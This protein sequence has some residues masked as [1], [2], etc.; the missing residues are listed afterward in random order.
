MS[1]IG[2]NDFGAGLS[3]PASQA[4]DDASGGVPS[5]AG[6]FGSGLFGR[7]RDAFAN[8]PQ[9]NTENP[10]QDRVNALAAGR[11][12]LQQSIDN[13]LRAF[14]KPRAWQED[15]QKAGELDNQLAQTQ[16]AMQNTAADRQAAYNGG[17]RP[18]T[19]NTLPVNATAK[20]IL[21]AW[22]GDY[23]GGS[24]NAMKYLG[25]LGDAG[26]GALAENEGNFMPALAER[27][28]QAE[29]VIDKL[30]TAAQA[31][32]PQYAA[33]LA[34]LKAQG[35][36]PSK[37]LADYVPNFTVPDKADA[38]NVRAQGVAG[39][40]AQAK[41][42]VAQYNTKQ[43]SLGLASPVADEKEE[44]AVQGSMFKGSDSAPIGHGSAT[45]VK[46]PNNEYG[47]VFPSGSAVP[48]SYM[49]PTGEGKWS[50]SSPEKVD[51]FNKIIASEQ[52]K[53]ALS[54][55]KLVKKAQEL[56]QNPETF[57]TAAGVTM[58]IGELGAVERDLS[59]GSRAAGTPGMS[60]MFE[61]VGLGSVDR[62]L[63]KARN[64]TSALKDWIDG[65]KK[66]PEPRLSD[67]TIKG[68]KA[69][70]QFK[71]D[72]SR[73]EISERMQ[74]PME[75]AGR[76]GIALNK[77]GLDK[78]LQNDPALLLAA[79]AGRDAFLKDYKSHKF[80]PQ[81]DAA[82]L[83]RQG[84]TNPDAKS[85]S[86]TQDVDSVPPRIVA[87]PGHELPPP[88]GKVFAPQGGDTQSRATA[89][90]HYAK[91]VN[92]GMATQPK[93][94]DPE[95][96][97]QPN[98]TPN[99]A[100]LLR[101]I[102]GSESNGDNPNSYNLIVGGQRLTNYDDHPGNINPKIGVDTKNGHSTASGAYQ[103]TKTTWNEVADKY[104]NVLDRDKNG[105]VVFTPQNQDKAAWLLA[106]ERYN[107]VTGGGNLEKDLSDPAKHDTVMKA[108]SGTWTSLPGG[109]EPN[110]ATASRLGALAG[111][112]KKVAMAFPPTA[113]SMALFNV[114]DARKALKDGA[115][116]SAPVLGSVGGALGGAAVGGIAGGVVGGAAGGAAGQAFKNYATGK[117]L[118]ENVGREAG[119][120][121]AAGL[122]PA[123][124]PI[125]GAIARSVGAGVVGATNEALTNPEAL[126]SDIL[127]KGAETGA[128]A[129]GGETA[130]R[131]VGLALGRTGQLFN[132]FTDETKQQLVDAGSVIAKGK[133]E[134]PKAGAAGV[135]V[136]ETA[137]AAHEA[138]LKAYEGAVQ[139]SK[140]HGLD[141]EDLAH[142]VQQ[143]P[144]G[145]VAV[146]KVVNA[147]QD[148]LGERHQEIKA[149]VGKQQ[150]QAGTPEPAPGTIR[151][152]H[153][154]SAD[155]DPTSYSAH[156]TP[157][158]NYARNFGAGSKT[159]HYVDMT[160]QEAAAQGGID[161]I[162]GNRPR[163]FQANEQTSSRLRPLSTGQ[164]L[165]APKQQPLTDGP[166]SLVGKHADVPKEYEGRAVQA[167]NNI[168]QP[169]KD[170]EQKY[171]QIFQERSKLLTEYRE[172]LPQ[173][174][175]PNA[176]KAAA[177]KAIADNVGDQ[178][179]NMLKYVYG[180]RGKAM[181]DKLDTLHRDYAEFMSASKG[182]D[183]VENMA[184]PGTAGASATAAFNRYAKDDAGARSVAEILVKG[185]RNPR[186][187]AGRNI[188]FMSALLASSLG[189]H[190]PTAALLL[191]TEGPKMLNEWALKRAAGA[192][193]TF[194]ELLISKAR[195][196]VATAK[197]RGAAATGRVAAEAVQ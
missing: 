61:A 164:N 169:A 95:G 124:R 177:L 112:T 81:G 36:N 119:L 46:L 159:V 58:V 86:Q 152:Y 125:L 187:D 176:N 128:A 160:P 79:N 1:D 56:A 188:K 12:R 121:G 102:R 94:G 40:L 87:S 39:Q 31:G 170:W 150:R 6:P 71:Y 25:T 104:G 76:N 64:E 139:T 55:Y 3:D 167:E 8:R 151:Y 67:S 77:T 143:V 118:A 138:D 195:Q 108:L 107:K 163:I 57:R 43:S 129:L 171:Q 13:P 184:K 50:N 134:A 90:L 17:L 10:V 60:K 175:A 149:D 116:D 110:G 179:R 18:E 66:G 182:G 172:A 106:Q 20:T 126:P 78:E 5:S 154:A 120:G 14:L 84:T 29:T 132:K 7:Q 155:A 146:N 32:Q 21:N 191:A 41:N 190:L 22:V 80:V 123:G 49:K 34:Q 38:W 192:P 37:V 2:I 30:N 91:A 144:A 109:S 72:Q 47:S 59:E 96:P 103:F 168:T 82:I 100:N 9:L 85:F 69:A 135:P 186:S 111:Y 178:Q 45:T 35:I 52:N 156:L 140:D 99:G 166:L 180:P 23:A 53:G 93:P 145:K 88:G 122:M 54:D 75:F 130:F 19:L 117:P 11:R 33:T 137:K 197:S 51:Q 113:A 158:Q 97:I 92:G 63:N 153:G 48:D 15:V 193:T 83:L 133:P 27:N 26:K 105:K 148:A 189:L 98:V 142:A 174:D 74:Q 28:T 194:K 62:W 65:G 68:I 173:G 24:W 16:Q 183:V 101:T 42:A 115:V 89:E 147:Q 162:N 44:K 161:E 185:I 4:A 127:T 131:V 181:A 196:S 165:G 141:P 73:R 70:I 157:D 136:S 114:G